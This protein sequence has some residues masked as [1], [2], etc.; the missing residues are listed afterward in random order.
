METMRDIALQELNEYRFNRKHIDGKI[1]QAIEADPAIKAKITQ[2]VELIEAY[3]A[4][5][6]YDSK[7]RRIAQL[8][9][10]DLPTLVMDIFTGIAYVLKPELFTS[11]T[12]QM[13][14]RLKFSDKA[15]AIT[16][17]AEL[18]AVLCVTDAFDIIKQGK[19]DSLMVM[20]RITLP[21]SLLVF[22]ENSIH[23]PP[24]VCEPKELTSNFTSGYLTHNDSLILGSGNSHDGDICLDVLNTINRVAL[25]LDT[26]FLSQ[27]EEE[28]NEITPEKIIAKAMKNGKHLSMADAKERVRLA[29]ENWDNFKTQSYE[30][31]RLMVQQGNK[32]WLTHKVDKRGRIY[33]VGYH[34]HTQG[35]A[36]KKASIEL[37]K[38]EI[39][40]G[41]PK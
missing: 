2:G 7:M 13:A 36:F 10:L 30:M 33:S 5:Q 26:D 9:H 3:M 16:T 12:A 14:S 41:V 22:I 38:Q 6:Y 11:V 15:E 37:H 4:G 18:L 17:V 34:I 24:M 20:S 19:L 39:V 29:L 27:V 31:Y 32:F 40:E 1:R 8:E 25:K 35:T 28:P 23:L 21:E